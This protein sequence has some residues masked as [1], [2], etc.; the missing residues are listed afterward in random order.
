MHLKVARENAL[1]ARRARS[2][3]TVESVKVDDA[4]RIDGGIR[5][6]HGRCREKSPDRGDRDA[7]DSSTPAGARDRD[8]SVSMRIHSVSMMLGDLRRRSL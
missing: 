1:T 4:H 3:G 5:R 2:S 6:R 7:Q 8:V